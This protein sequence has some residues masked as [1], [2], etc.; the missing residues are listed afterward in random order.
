M[1]YILLTWKKK[2]YKMAYISWETVTGRPA[3][4]SLHTYIKKSMH[5][6]KQNIITLLYLS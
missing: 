2:S 1:K 6:D 5:K 3:S 4:L